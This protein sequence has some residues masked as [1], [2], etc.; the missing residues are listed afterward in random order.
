M[1]I[2]QSIIEKYQLTQSTN[3]IGEGIV[4]D[5]LCFKSELP[6]FKDVLFM[7]C[8]LMGKPSKEITLY[9]K[10]MKRKISVTPEYLEAMKIVDILRFVV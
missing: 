6:G 9:N 5:L 10:T 3:H 2:P 7:E 1:K 4:H 8:D